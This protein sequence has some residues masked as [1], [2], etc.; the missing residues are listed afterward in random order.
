MVAEHTALVGRRIAEAREEAGLTQAELAAKIPGKAGS[1]QVSK[2]E[3]GIHRPGDDTLAQIG[4]A[5]GKPLAWFHTSPADKS[6]GTPALMETL[7]PDDDQSQLDRIEAMLAE[8]LRRVPPTTEE[9]LDAA[10]TGASTAERLSGR[11]A[12]STERQASQARRAKGRP[13]EAPAAGE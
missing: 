10:K 6:N 8:L 9:L 3:R 7:E 1:D 2:W 13:P 4:K 11:P 12:G 5:T